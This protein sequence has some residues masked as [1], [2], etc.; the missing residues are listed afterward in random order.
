MNRVLVMIAITAV[1]FTAL[2]FIGQ[3]YVRHR[4]PDALNRNTGT[5]MKASR[6]NEEGLDRLDDGKF[7]EAVSKFRAAMDL[8]PADEAIAHNLSLGLARMAVARSDLGDVKAAS[9]YLGEAL[10]VWPENPEALRTM[11][12]I[13]YR[14]GRYVESRD[15]ALRLNAFYPGS[16]DVEEFIAHLQTVIEES[17]GMVSEDGHHFRLLYSGDRRLEFE[18]EFLSLLQDE[19]DSLT[20]IM[21][22]FPSNV[23]DVLLMTGD[24]GL[25]AVPL[26]PSLTGLYDGKIR[27]Y[28]DEIE[29][30]EGVRKTVRHEMVHALL[31]QVGGVLPGWFQ[32][33]MAQFLGE[34]Y[35]EGEDPRLRVYLRTRLDEGY[36]LDLTG[37]G[38][39]FVDLPDEGRTAAYASSYLFMEYLVQKYGENLIPIIIGE[40]EG[41]LGLVPALRELTGRDLNT[42]QVE[43]V[44]SIRKGG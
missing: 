34:R 39:S 21:G 17:E 42:L 10:D 26:D 8:K 41:G 18:G 4:V 19:M 29:D 44:E 43:F 12:L 7:T 1:G 37:L 16:E 5:V 31:H 2:F 9:E 40:L 14:S 25:R 35:L 13:H 30:V 36:G 27:V 11:A 32:E 6:L 33:G 28:L 24:L 22:Y 3:G 15:L 38:I 23:I 20:A